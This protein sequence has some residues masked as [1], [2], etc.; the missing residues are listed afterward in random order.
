ML[1]DTIFDTLSV[2]Y[3]VE[4]AVR[5]VVVQELIRAWRVFV[6]SET[7]RRFGGRRFSYGTKVCRYI[8][9]TVLVADAKI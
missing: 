6:P 5:C 4:K 7:N 3:S 8:I 9:G 2:P 1:F